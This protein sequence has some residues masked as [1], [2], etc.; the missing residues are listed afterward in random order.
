MR[1]SPLVP[2]GYDNGSVCMEPFDMT[3]VIA[4]TLNSN[5]YMDA[6]HHIDYMEMKE[7]Q[8]N[9]ER[10]STDTKSN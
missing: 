4:A 9:Y 7:H 5:L 3:S 2:S 1:H 6:L 10:P 8:T